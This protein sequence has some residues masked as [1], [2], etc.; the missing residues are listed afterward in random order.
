MK[1]TYIKSHVVARRRSINFDMDGTIADLYGV[2]DWL[3]LLRSE[4]PAPYLMAVPM[5]DMSE[6]NEVCELLRAEGWEINIITWLSKDSSEEYKNLVREAKRTWLEEQG[7]HYDHF[8]G[9]QYGA[10]K[11]DSVRDRYDVSILIDDNEKVRNGWHLGD[12]IDPTAVN[13]IEK[14]SE[15]LEKRA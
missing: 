13:I 2:K 14:L 5:C 3:A 12:T 7:F 1:I 4:N 15:L 10:T 6:L 9:V 8:H 11:A